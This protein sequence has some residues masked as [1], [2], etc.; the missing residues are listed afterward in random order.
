MNPQKHVVL[1]LSGGVDSAVAGLLLKQA[2]FRVSAVFMQNWDTD[3]EDPFCTANQDLSDARAIC[4]QLDIPLEHVN[5][6]K[7]YWDNVFQHCLDEFAKGRTP[8][9]DVLCNREIKFKVF[10]DYAMKMGADFL[11]TG[12]Y[13]RIREEEG[14]YHLLKASDETKDQSYFLYMLEEAV[15]SKTLF[16]LGEVNKSEVRLLAKN[17]G[18]I[19]SDKKDSTGICFIGERKFKDFL[20]EFL[21]AQPGV[22]KT[23]KGEV[24]GQHEGIIYYTLGQRKGLNIGGVKDREEAA[25]YVIDKIIEENVLIVEQ[26]SEHPLM[27]KNSL[28]CNQMHWISGKPKSMHLSAKHRYR[29]VDQACTLTQLN[30]NEYRVDFEVPQRAI[31]PGQSIVFYEGDL[32]LGGGIISQV[33]SP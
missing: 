29:Q 17:A 3:N 11:A 10:F 7:E 6:A 25:W 23:S 4:D 22:I 16:P 32:C 15:L 8:N 30:E 1:G 26:G 19:N 2:G 27:Y 12:H 33:E 21:L 14:R 28:I 18:F 9:P 31:T 24:I 13:A 20:K 5:F